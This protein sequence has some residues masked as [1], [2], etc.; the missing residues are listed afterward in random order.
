M[1]YSWITSWYHANY[2]FRHTSIANTWTLLLLVRAP[3]D[4]SLTAARQV[5]FFFWMA[6]IVLRASLDTIAR[7]VGVFCTSR[8]LLTMSFH[9]ERSTRLVCLLTLFP[10][11]FIP[12][13]TLSP[14]FPR[15]VWRVLKGVV[16]LWSCG[17]WGVFAGLSKFGSCRQKTR[18]TQKVSLQAN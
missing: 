6:L 10:G 1:V 2:P 13:F 16:F 7:L 12:S 15:A 5:Q 18:I 4:N 11:H 9:L 3:P 14:I 17:N 8:S